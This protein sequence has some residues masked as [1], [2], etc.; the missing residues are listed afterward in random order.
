M[1]AAE[2]V[3]LYARVSGDRQEK[4]ATIETQLFKLRERVEAESLCLH[5]EYLDNPYTGTVPSRPGLDRLMADARKGLFT[6][7]LIYHPDRLARGKPWLRPALEEQLALLGVRI[8][9]LT[10]K[11]EDS[12]EGRAQDGML[13]VF[14]EWEREHMQQRMQ[15]GR[16]NKIA[17]GG[18]W[19]GRTFA[20]R[21]VQP[22]RSSGGGQREDGPEAA[23]ADPADGRKKD[24][25]I[26][27]IE[28]LRP[29]ARLIFESAIAGRSL[30]W[31][32]LEL[33]RL[34]VPTVKGGTW[35]EAQVRAIIRNP[36]YAGRPT[37][38][39]YY[40]VEPKK[41]RKPY[42]RFST[43]ERPPEEWL[44]TSAPAIV[45]PDEQ[46]A[47]M[48]AL[49][50]N[51][52]L[53]RRN[54]K[55]EY[56]VAGLIFCGMPHGPEGAPCGRRLRG[57]TTGPEE[58]QR[59]LYRC[60]RT[61]P[62]PEA[63]RMRRCPGSILV[64]Q[65][66]AQVWGELTHLFRH[67]E[68]LAEQ[69]KAGLSETAEERAVAQATLERAAIVLEDVK[70]RLSA[71]FD[72][73]LAGMDAEAFEAKQ[74]E[75]VGQR[76]HAREAF[77]QAQAMLDGS[78]QSAA[79]LLDLRAF[80]DAVVDRLEEWERPEHFAQRQAFVRKFIKRVTVYPDR[81]EILGVLGEPPE[82]STDDR[83]DQFDYV[84]T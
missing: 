69:F 47:A 35:T 55:R 40:H 70:A 1:T 67:P 15:D 76:T 28:E 23:A 2:R 57:M 65:A 72:L 75:L 81:L 58:R 46:A 19:R 54:T 9:Y 60:N 33:I 39:R 6:R 37:Y 5:D 49:A 73:R 71:L 63:M 38:G 56:L 7:V 52:V 36:L 27:V 31:I 16:L 11:V 30:R 53:G 66:D 10:Y 78:K 26:E 44:H 50:R 29:F 74:A 24:G 4:E 34:G 83:G 77:E 14:A 79:R 48:A 8:T 61:I 17:R 18:N 32:A 13:T 68:E 84:T 25:R 82:Q 62:D 80:S 21:Y 45:T 43:R 41:R 51:K 20:Y 59:R 3:A 64:P 42:T 22:G 12:P